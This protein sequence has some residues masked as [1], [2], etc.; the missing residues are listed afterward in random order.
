MLSVCK[1]NTLAFLVGFVSYLRKDG[2]PFLHLSLNFLKD[3]ETFMDT[4]P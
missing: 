2:C 1:N 4:C 3:N